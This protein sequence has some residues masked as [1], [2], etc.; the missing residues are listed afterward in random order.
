MI[1]LAY[2]HISSY[3]G[4]NGKHVLDADTDV[5]VLRKRVNAYMASPK[6][7]DYNRRTKYEIPEGKM[8]SPHYGGSGGGCYYTAWLTIEEVKPLTI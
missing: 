3:E 1:Y 4:P 2:S 7:M 6:M 5:D 8:E